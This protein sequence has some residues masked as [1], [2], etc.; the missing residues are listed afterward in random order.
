MATPFNPNAVSEMGFMPLDLVDVTVGR[1]S[2]K[3]HPKIMSTMQI[4][5]RA[6]AWQINKTA[7]FNLPADFKL[8]IDAFGAQL[9]ATST[10]EG[11]VSNWKHFCADRWYNFHHLT[12]MLFH[13]SKGTVMNDTTTAA[14]A[15]IL[16]PV[17]NGVVAAC[18]QQDIKFV[19][20][21]C[22][23]NFA[24]LVTALPYPTGTV[25]CVAYYIEL[26]Q[27]THAMTNG[28]GGAYT[29]VSYLG[30]A[31]LHTLTPPEVKAQTLD[32]CLQDGPVLLQASNF[33][34]A[35]ANT[36]ANAF[37]INNERKILKIAW[38]QICTSIFNEIYPEYS[39]Q[40]QAALE[41]I[42]QSY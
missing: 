33:N 31:N 5:D 27:G 28:N 42:K 25:L 10:V 3:L 16:L 26:P 7:L 15:Q 40:P 21:Q 6:H 29:L 24:P 22:V 11:I 37:A 14:D 9:N 32:V 13:N 20:V 2:T 38:H 8:V 41:H 18:R 30:P 39:N 23:I 12:I 19:W 17:Q 35:T 4:F 1:V 34:L 36:D